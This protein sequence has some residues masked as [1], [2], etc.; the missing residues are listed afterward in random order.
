MNDT[1][2]DVTKL[3]KEMGVSRSLLHKKLKALTNM[4]TTEFIRLCRLKKSI[5]YLKHDNLNISEVA[6]EV[7]FNDPKYFSRIFKKHFGVTPTEYI[8]NEIELP[9]VQKN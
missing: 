3:V 4:S 5:H 1:S 6:Y 2:F 9:E 8:S 7:G